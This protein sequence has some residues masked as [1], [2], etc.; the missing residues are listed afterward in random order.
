MVSPGSFSSTMS[1]SVKNFLVNFGPQHP[2][3]HGV[4]RLV[5]ELD[6]EIVRRCDP[7]LG[8][9]HRGSEKLMEY[10]TFLQALPY[11]DRFD[12][13]SMMAQE[14]AYSLAVERLF[15]DSIYATY[16]ELPKLPTR[17]EHIRVLFSEITRI[18]NH[19][20]ATTTH[21]MD[22]GALTPFLWAFDEREKLMEFYE[23]VSGAR[24]H[25][26]YIRPGG[27]AFDLPMGLLNDI[28]DFIISFSSRLDEIAELL[29][30]SRILLDRVKGVGVASQELALSYGF[31]GVM[32]R[33]SGIAWDL[34]K[35]APYDG[36]DKWKFNVP[37][38]T[39]GDCYDRFLVR[40]QEMRESLHI[41]DQVVNTMALGSYKFD[42]HQLVNPS[43]A[44]FKF[45]MENLI[46]HF[47]IYSQG[48][49]FPESAIYASVEAP[50]GEFGVF[51][52]G[53]ENAS[54]PYRCRARAPGFF[55]LA[56]LDVLARGHFLA[57]V[58]AL[59]GTLDLVFGEV[60]R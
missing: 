29:N 14:Q 43:R 46:H 31:S 36:Y 58:V 53:Q 21:A 3:A 47:K 59:I 20:M 12:Y 54:K 42:F 37:V 22:L 38:G 50:K 60:D 8:L 34:R 45:F 32:L 41:M 23:R 49:T 57:D 44:S 7:H 33:G 27:V 56:A 13:V 30:E 28:H 10:K 39:Q 1:S 55:H 11:F 25:A 6:G 40:I 18:L 15:F 26:A 2:A 51:V 5:L 35:T 48:L 4:L 16:G 9:L 17:A 52:H 24:M 19:I